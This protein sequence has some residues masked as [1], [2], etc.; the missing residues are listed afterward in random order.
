M[1]RFARF[2][3][4]FLLVAS[5]V[6]PGNGTSAGADGGDVHLV[7]ETPQYVLD[8][9]GLRVPGYALSDAPGEPQLPIWTTMVEVPFGADWSVTEAAGNGEQVLYAPALL[10]SAPVTSLRLRGPAKAL[11]LETVAGAISV[12][13]HPDPAIYG[14]DALYPKQ[15]VHSGP[16]GIARGRRLLPLRIYPFQYNPATGEIVYQ[17]RIEVT[18]H[19]TPRQATE[20]SG[21]RTSAAAPAGDASEPG[22]RIR[23]T[24]RGLYR[25]TYEVLRDAGVPVAELNPAQMAMWYVNQPVDIE[26]TGTGDGKFGPGDAVVFYAEP[27]AGRYMTQNVY[28]L[29][30]SGGPGSRIGVRDGAPALAQAPLTTIRQRARVEYDRSYY[31]TY[32]DLARDA[33]HFFDDPLYPNVSAPGAAVT[34][35]LTLANA[36]PSGNADLTVAVHGGQDLGGLNPD[37]SLALR[38]NGTPLG[39]YKWDGSVTHIITETV[40]AVRLV[41]GANTLVL[42][43]SLSQLPGI[44]YY[45]VSPDWAEL[46]YPAKADATNNQLYIET[47][48]GL[49][50]PLLPA[51]YLPLLTRDTPATDAGASAA[52][53]AGQERANGRDV[54]AGGFTAPGIWVYDVSDARHP[55]LLNGV[56]E[57]SSNGRFAVT[58]AGRPGASYY[59]AT[60]GGLR[61]PAAIRLDAPSTLRSPA[62][63]ADYIAVVHRSLWDAV[64]PLLDHRGAGGLRVAKVD[65]Q[66]VYDE[67]SGGR[68]DPEALRTF[69]SYAYHNWNQGGPRPQYVLLV[70]DGHYDFKGALRPDLP[71]L[72]PPYLLNID[73]FIGET[74]ADNR[75]VSVDGDADF[76]PDMALG[77]IPAKSPSDVTAVVDK[78]LAYEKSAAAGDWQKRVAFVADNKDDPVGNFHLMSEQTRADAAAA[79]RL[80][81]DLLQVVDGSGYSCRD[82]DGD[83]VGVQ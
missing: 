43:A 8:E 15:V 60:D 63:D 31:G 71:N 17:P 37:Q 45:W 72:I 4:I 55:I 36:A 33:D 48:I 35:T 21:V 24:E 58:F 74:A 11:D 69:L 76:L 83:K 56:K 22:V 26:V 1:P 14:A 81:D 34:Y 47:V 3:A 73:P 38:L 66:D 20:T 32:T 82:E 30:W 41:S 61:E 7:V 62:N 42:Q 5:I 51:L 64:Q 80:A 44:D 19:F 49:E 13:S 65:V 46:A 6:I 54:A 39:P 75:F 23:T 40:P 68:V 78:I 79:V 53:T 18:V 52:E 67:F 10:P 57:S 12:E 25:L 77:R 27:Y 70:G 29:S 28:R 59:L 16:E 9:Q 50:A 2:F